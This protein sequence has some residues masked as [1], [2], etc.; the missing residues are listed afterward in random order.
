M[1]SK[2]KLKEEIISALHLSDETK[3]REEE[4][5]EE[6]ERFRAADL[7]QDEQLSR[8]DFFAFLYPR[9]YPVCLFYGIQLITVLIF[10]ANKIY[11][12]SG[13]YGKFRH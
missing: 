2:I 13:G 9:N 6:I 10:L 5:F 12:Y 8:E 3:E 7:N 1:Y 4:M 11:L